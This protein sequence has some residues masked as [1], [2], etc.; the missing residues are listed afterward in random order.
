MRHNHV[1]QL[2]TQIHVRGFQRTTGQRAEA[3]AT[4]SPERRVTGRLRLFPHVI[5]FGGQPFWVRE[6]NHDDLAEQL[7]LLVGISPYHRTITVDLEAS[8]FTGGVA[9]LVLCNN[10]V[11]TGIL[12]FTARN[13]QCETLCGRT[14]NHAHRDRKR[15]VCGTGCICTVCHVFQGTV[16]IKNHRTTFSGSS[17]IGRVCWVGHFGATVPGVDVPSIPIGRIFS[18]FNIK[19]IDFMAVTQAIKGR[20]VIDK[21]V[22]IWVI[23]IKR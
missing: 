12:L 19:D 18:T 7:G 10:A 13:I 23:G 14:I 21:A 15:E 11:S 3:T 8:K 6:V 16:T 4:G 9:S 5:A 1:H 17:R 22:G 20:H 2:F